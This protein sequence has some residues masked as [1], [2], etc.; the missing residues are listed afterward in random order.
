MYGNISANTDVG[1]CNDDIID[2]ICY[3]LQFS[4]YMLYADDLKI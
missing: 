2:D 1:I 4:N 3:C